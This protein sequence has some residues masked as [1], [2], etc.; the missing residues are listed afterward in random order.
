MTQTTANARTT[1]PRRVVAA[2][3]ATFV[4]MAGCTALLSSASAADCLTFA[5]PK[6]DP[7]PQTVVQGQP[8]V[9]P[10]DNDP[11]LDLLATTV[12]TVGDSL[13]AVLKVEDLIG[14]PRNHFSDRFSYSFTLNAKAFTV[15]NVR[16]EIPI[17]PATSEL[18][19]ENGVTV[20]GTTTE[21]LVKATY[22]EKANTVT[23]AVKTADIDK[24]AG[25]PSADQPLS[26]FSSRAAAVVV[27]TSVTY[28][29]ATAPA[30]AVYVGGTACG[31]GGESPTASGS[32][33]VA[34]SG[35]A[36]PAPSGSASPAPSGS[37]TPAPSGSAS[38]SGSPDGGSGLLAAPRK[39]C[40]SIPDAAGDA[41]P[42]GTGQGNEASL[43][44]TA[45]NFLTK[46][47]QLQVWV[48]LAN[49]SAALRPIFTTRRYEV[50]FT[51]A[52]K[53]VVLTVPGAAAGTAS[54]GGT[55][56]PDAKTAATIDTKAATLVVTVDRAGLEKALGAP[57]TDGTVLSATR[58]ATSAGNPA[59]TRA[60]DTAQKAKADEQVYTVGDNTCFLPPAGK[61]EVLAD[62]S[63]QF[64]D[65]TTVFATLTDSA[66]QPVI[67]QVVSVRLG[68]GAQV[69]ATTDT[70]GTAELTVPLTVPASK[71]ALNVAYAGNADVG[72]TTA[73]VPFA[74]VAEK[75]VLSA[76]G[77]RGTVTATLLDDDR[78][79]VVGQVVTFVQ[80]GLKKTART[81]GKGVA[82]A[83][84]FKVGAPV[85][86]SYAGLPGRYTAVRT[87]AK[88]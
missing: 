41:D 42:T 26:A 6:G 1:A 4:A 82:K 51:A 87:S 44:V 32:P 29:L 62:P 53:A 84:G 74:V 79:K 24:L 76:K 45:V 67:G 10:V 15:F 40:V 55:A 80:G 58:V 20:A 16:H 63:G 52:T 34:A 37:A 50:F 75:S 8:V 27:G 7:A 11:H 21:N 43:D 25:K 38:P 66:D 5:D 69:S 3:A 23:L 68:T 85:T 28:D 31:G 13:V 65:D 39:D 59:T 56:A 19:F 71:T 49:P 22:D 78:S 72:A 12:E 17:S 86:V 46:T 61:L 18:F 81:D 48:K 70:D 83:A 14:A 88:A 47:D 9:A 36:S 30:S 2:A 33:T 57:L 60:A 35:S 64:S 77:A 73:S 54:V